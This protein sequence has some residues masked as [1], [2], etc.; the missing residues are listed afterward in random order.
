MYF[1]RYTANEVAQIITDLQDDLV[2]ADIYILPPDGNQSEEDSGDDEG[3]TL[4]NLQGSQ[5]TSLASARVNLFDGSTLNIGDEEEDDDLQSHPNQPGTSQR[6]QPGTSQRSQSGTSQRNEPGTLQRNQTGPAQASGDQE[7]QFPQP[8]QTERKWIKGELQANPAILEW[9]GSDQIDLSQKTPSDVFDLFFDEEVLQ[10]IINQTNL[11]ARRDRDNHNFEI[12]VTELRNF[13][14]ILIISGYSTV[15]RKRMYW[16]LNPDSHNEAISNAMSRNRFDEIMKYIHFADNLQLPENDK[17]GK[18]R[19]FMSM[20]NE[21]CLLFFPT[22]QNLSIDESMIPYY[23]RHSSKQRMQG[24]PIRVGYKM[25]VMSTPEGYVVQFDPY[26]GTKNGQSMK[27][28]PTTW[29]L[30][31]HVVLDLISELPEGKPFHIYIDNYFT[32]IRLFEHLSALGFGAVGTIRSN[33]ISHCPMDI[34]KLDKEDRGTHDQYIDTA[35]SIALVG[36]KDNKVVLLASNCF[37]TFP[38]AQTTR[39]SRQH[40]AR[41]VITQPHVVRMYNKSMGGV[42]RTDQNIGQYRIAIRSKKWW[43]P[44]FAWVV[45][46][47]LQNCWLLHRFNNAN[48]IDLLTMRREIV[49]VNLARGSAL[50]RIARPQQHFPIICSKVPDA[51]RFDGQLHYPGD[52]D[53]QLRCSVCK[54][55]TKKM[56]KKCNIGIHLQCFEQFHTA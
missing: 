47:V 48:H 44:F 9:T 26:Q 7:P 42:D 25:W 33:R 21:R 23:G 6:N 52:A 13:L 12:S 32:S 50:R 55:N 27:S 17:M 34:K 8:P 35:G 15:S 2:D 22:R 36:W 28:T 45:D 38:V 53:R 54:K 4:D 16:E 49:R 19:N 46:M 14:S 3:G 20:I 43:W 41:V 40:N 18:V 11:Y 29:G 30:G 1:R 31:E 5:L 56:C 51:V 24:K 37:D 39:W 10:Y